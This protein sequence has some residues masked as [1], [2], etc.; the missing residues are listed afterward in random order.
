[1]RVLVMLAKV[2][3]NMSN[4]VEFGIKE[5]GLNFLND[6]M[7]Q[8]S[9]ALSKFFNEIVRVRNNPFIIYFEG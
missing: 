9:H 4:H 8:N 1:M 3:Q 5:P 7:R 6:L 2:L